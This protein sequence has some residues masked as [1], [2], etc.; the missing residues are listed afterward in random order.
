MHT[1]N[2]CTAQISSLWRVALRP[3]CGHCPAHPH[4]VRDQCYASQAVSVFRMSDTKQQSKTGR[5]KVAIH[6]VRGWRPRRGNIRTMRIFLMDGDVGIIL[7]SSKSH[8]SLD[9]TEV[10]GTRHHFLLHFLRRRLGQSTVY[11][12]RKPSASSWL[13]KFSKLFFSVLTKR[14]SFATWSL[15]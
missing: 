9:A 6:C 14:E 3:W 5:E 12:T 10:R 2:H 15:P 8:E 13:L 11:S 1:E 7:N 4:L